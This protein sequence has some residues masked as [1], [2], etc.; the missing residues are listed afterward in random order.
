MRDCVC[1]DLKIIRSV[2]LG[3]HPAELRVA[4]YVV[5]VAVHTAGLGVLV[6]GTLTFIPGFYYTR[7]AYLAW[8]GLGDYSEMPNLD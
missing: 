5:N 4:S 2:D 1:K 3:N 8:K 6:L 7:V